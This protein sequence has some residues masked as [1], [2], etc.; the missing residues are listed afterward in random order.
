LGLADIA[1]HFFGFTI[2]C[3]MSILWPHK[4]MFKARQLLSDLACLCP[5]AITCT[6]QKSHDYKALSLPATPEQE[7][8]MRLDMRAQQSI[9]SAINDRLESLH[10]SF[11]RYSV[12]MF[13]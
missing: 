3:H 13:R 7:I 6:R 12:P 1:P 11:A 4:Y 8:G 5:P 10:S 9:I 2:A